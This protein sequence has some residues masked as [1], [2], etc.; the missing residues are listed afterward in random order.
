MRE[1]A[2]ES[3][4]NIDETAPLLMSFEN[5]AL[6]SDEA[7][8]QR[9]RVSAGTNTAEDEAAVLLRLDR[10]LELMQRVGEEDDWLAIAKAGDF[11]VVRAVFNHWSANCP[12]S[13]RLVVCRNLVLFFKLVPD[14]VLRVACGPGGF[15]FAGDDGGGSDGGGAEPVESEK[16][17]VFVLEQMLDGLKEAKAMEGDEL[18]EMREEAV[19]VWMILAESMF[20]EWQRCGIAEEELPH[21]ALVS[22]MFDVLEGTDDFAYKATASAIIAANSHFGDR[23]ANVVMMTL[24]THKNKALLAEAMLGQLNDLGYPNADTPSL[25]GKLRSLLQALEDVFVLPET[26]DF[27]YVNDLNVLIDVVLRELTNLPM[28]D[29]LT[30]NYLQVLKQLLLNSQ[31]FA[32]GDRYR[33]EDICAALESMHEAATEDETGE[34]NAEA[35]ELIDDLFEECYAI[36]VE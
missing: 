34:A 19:T 5:L 29:E 9:R 6:L 4:L 26:A 11:R 23:G 33:R 36:L 17:I 13:V 25:R 28:S 30:C 12:P 8:A 1:A 21:R 7:E 16:S 35:L 27:F 14:A 24:K 31:W 10:L 32:R 2:R 18:R 20:A 22:I 3:L 15:S